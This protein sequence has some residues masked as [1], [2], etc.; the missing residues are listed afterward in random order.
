VTDPVT[1]TAPSTSDWIAAYRRSHDRLVRVAS[2]LSE[3]RLRSQSYDD[4][5]SVAQVLSHL[6]SGAQIFT[7]ILQAGLAGVDAP[8]MDVMQPIWAEWDAKGPVAM[9]DDALA[10]DGALVAAL[11]DLGDEE[12]AAFGIPLWFG[13]A[14]IDDVV[15]MRMAEHAVHVWDVEVSFDRSAQ[16]ADDAVAL[17]LPGL[18]ATAA[19]SGKV[20][21]EPFSA[22]LSTTDGR[23]DWTVAAGDPVT[24][25]PSVPGSD[26]SV[27][28][29]PSEA[30][31]RLVYGRLDPDHEPAG[32]EQTGAHGLADLRHVFQGF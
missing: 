11:E 15:R 10:V 1:G 24:L 6:G 30:L 5:W 29:L 9:R 19:R 21:A 4:E 25:S 18:G 16:V 20:P 8:G 7:L 22:A 12:R 28:R 26:L 17:L 32:I 27:V 13:P 23:G 3:E 31:L 2:G 14:T